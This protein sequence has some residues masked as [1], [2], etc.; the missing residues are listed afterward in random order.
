MALLCF[1]LAGGIGCESKPTGLEGLDIRTVTLPD[2][3]QERA[4]LKVNPADMAR[5]MMYRDSL[6]DGR[7]ML[8]VH[9]QQGLNPYWMG[10]CNIPLDMIW[11]DS[12]HKVVEISP[13]TPPCPTGGP[14]CPSYG[15]HVPSQYVLEIGS[16]QASRHGVREGLSLQF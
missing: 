2:G 3:F 8:F 6:A 9:E 12:E 14:E 5:G 15:G 11:M 13:A 16:G 1:A 7:G 10:H 4:E